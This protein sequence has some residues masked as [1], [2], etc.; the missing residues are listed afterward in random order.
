MFEEVNMFKIAICDDNEMVCSKIENI[1]EEFFV[2]E[3]IHYEI[4]SFQSGEEL[5]KELENHEKYDLI[6]LDIELETINGVVV[7]RFIR[8]EMFDDFTQIAFISAKASYALELFQVRPIDFLVKPFTYKQVITV[9]EKALELQ[10]RQAK[11]FRYKSGKLENRMP[12][13]DIMYFSS[14]GKKIIIHKRNGEDYFYGKLSELKLP[15]KD[16][17]QIHK[18]FIVN[19]QYVIRFKFDSVRLSNAE[20]LPISRVYRKIVR[21]NLML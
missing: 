21:E 16:F 20:E 7:G 15:S 5:L 18:S 3:A 19:K 11:I 12:Y 4:D 9:L 2:T 17:I 10:G 8:E 6:Y 13:K 14:D 1:L